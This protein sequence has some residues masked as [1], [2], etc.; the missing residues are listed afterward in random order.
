MLAGSFQSIICHVVIG[1]GTMTICGLKVSRFVSSKRSGSRL[2]I[3]TS[4]PSECR[5]CK[6]CERIRI[7]E[8]EYAPET[9]LLRMTD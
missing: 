2:H 7:G 6:H 9:S 3:L 5:V 1:D 4:K 8:S